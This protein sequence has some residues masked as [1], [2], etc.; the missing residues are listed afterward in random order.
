MSYV[1][2][3]LGASNIR[4]LTL[5]PGS[6]GD[7]I[8]AA[9]EIFELS[10]SD[11]PDYEALSYTWGTPDLNTEVHVLQYGGF[12]SLFI[13]QNLAVA[14]QHLRHE[15]RPRRLWIDAVCINQ[16][17]VGKRN[18]QVARMAEVFGSAAK[19]IIWLGPESEQSTL[20]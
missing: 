16:K 15:Q 13:T 3:T 4:L 2:P 19:V 17:G 10:P 14:L 9:L 7:K 11:K 8:D 20:A 1:Y 18:S 5:H 12:K 6:V